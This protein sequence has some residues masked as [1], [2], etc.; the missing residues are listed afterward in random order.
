MTIC[1]LEGRKQGKCGGK[2]FASFTSFQIMN[3]LPL[4]KLE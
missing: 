2:S 1:Q 4:A 3:N